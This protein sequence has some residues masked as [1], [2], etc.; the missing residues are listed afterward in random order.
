MKSG[1]WRAIRLDNAV[2]ANRYRQC[3]KLPLLLPGHNL[4]RILHA[5]NPLKKL[6]LDLG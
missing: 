5:L 6:V 4:N 3:L 2:I 1:W